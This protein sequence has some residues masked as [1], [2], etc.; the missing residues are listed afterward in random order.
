MT[1]SEVIVLYVCPLVGL[2]L[3]LSMFLSNVV[4]MQKQTALKNGLGDV[5][6]MPYSTIFGNCIGGCIYGVIYQNQWVWW[7]NFPGV[8][9]GMYLSCEAL[10]VCGHRERDAAV[11]KN[12]VRS[13]LFWVG[14]WLMVGWVATFV[15]APAVRAPA[16]GFASSTAC[17]V[18]YAA[19]LST[20]AKVV[21]D[22]DASSLY[23]PMCAIAATC[24]LLWTVYGLA[25]GDVFIWIPNGCGMC[26]SATQLTLIALLPSKGKPA[27]FEEGKP[28]PVA[29]DLELGSYTSCSNSDASAWQPVVKGVV[30]AVKDLSNGLPLDEVRKPDLGP[31]AEIPPFVAA[32]LPSNTSFENLASHRAHHGIVPEY[33]DAFGLEGGGEGGGASSSAVAPKSSAFSGATLECAICLAPISGSAPSFTDRGAEAKDEAAMAVELRCGHR[34]CAPC[35]KK[36]AANDLA[37]CPT[38]RHPHELDPVVLQDRLDAY[39]G[40]YQNWRKGGTSGA[41][42]EVDDISAAAPARGP[43]EGT[44]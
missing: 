30:V 23:L 13:L 42:G 2:L 11:R 28:V 9:I 24:T 25:I 1:F 36:C 15:L 43:T 40:N 6:P 38:C 37:S 3:G 17:V 21:R 41:K 39:R 12:L 34:F 20:L 19:P 10:A 32:L 33:R 8:L 26:L 4:N 16:V 5:N 31:I 27:A 29:V 22:R 18:L 44:I 7:S 14:F 35:M